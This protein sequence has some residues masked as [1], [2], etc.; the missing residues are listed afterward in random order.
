VYDLT[1]DTNGAWIKAG[2]PDSSSFAVPTGDIDIGDAAAEGAAI[3]HS[4]ADHQHQFSAPA[5]GYPL[6]VAAAEDDGVGTAPARSDHVHAHG[7][8]YLPDAH[9]GQS[10]SDSDHTAGFGTPTGAIDIGDAAAEGVATTHSR[11]DHQHQ[12]TAPSGGYPLDVAAAEADGVASTTA[13][14]DHV[15]A[16]GSG[17]L[18]NAHHTDLSKSITIE[19]PVV[20]NDISMFFTN[21]AITVTEM[22]IVVRGTTPSVTVD[23]RHGT[24]RSAA[25][26]ALI[27]SPSATTSESTG[28]DIVAFDDATVIA[29]SFVW[30]E[31]DAQSGTVDEVHITI[32]YTTD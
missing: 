12:F 23:V 7:S 28:D 3:T 2:D 11:A 15:H 6:D 10:H 19:D 22:R 17:Y 24:D 25:G 1:L 26:A 5:G 9:H 8:G 27:T 4:R 14:A 30:I 13:R 20:G 31:F 32:F 18:P 16:H 29:N 21:K